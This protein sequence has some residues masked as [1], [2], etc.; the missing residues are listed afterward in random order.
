MYNEAGQGREIYYSNIELGETISRNPILLDSVDEGLGTNAPT[1]IEQEGILYVIYYRESANKNV[2]TMRTSSDSGHTWGNITQLFTRHVGVNGSLSPVIDGNG[3]LHLFFGQR[4]SGSPDIHGIWHSIWQNN[5]WKEPEA[6]IKGPQLA[7][8]RVADYQATAVVSQGN[9]IIVT[10]ITDP[11]EK[12]NGVWFSYKKLDMEESPVIQLPKL[13]E[14]LAEPTPTSLEIA[15]KEAIS[16]NTSNLER[17]N[18]KLPESNFNPNAT[19][20]IAG[21]SVLS[22][23]SIVII[24][25]KYA[26]YNKR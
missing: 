21:I 3:D 4:I 13:M 17:P 11:G 16:T 24:I 26:P 6:V 25:K 14:P 18:T 7:D 8:F 2:I 22:L 5:R 15:T 23:I 19:I 9:T 1:I 20:I 12:G 10:W